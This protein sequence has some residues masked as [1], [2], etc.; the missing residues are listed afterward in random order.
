MTVTME[1]ADP[2]YRDGD[3]VRRDKVQELLDTSPHIKKANA[4]DELARQIDVDV[5]T[6]L[7][8]VERYH[9]AFDAGLEAE[10][11]F[12]KSLKQSKRFDTPPYY[13]VQL[14]PLARQNFGGVK[15]DLRCRV[16]NRYF[17]GT[18]ITDSRSWPMA[19]RTRSTSSTGES[20]A[21]CAC[22]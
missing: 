9:K 20:F 10:P 3:R 13:A 1:V 19:A 16:L 5:P 17:A 6:F 11:A 22:R 2:Y 4:L 8:E 12:S 7:G 14:F 15:T 18:A 21:P